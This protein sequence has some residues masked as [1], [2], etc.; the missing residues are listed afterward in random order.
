MEN[1][2]VS[3]EIDFILVNKLDTTK[4][5][6]TVLLSDSKLVIS[7]TNEKELCALYWLTVKRL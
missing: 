2:L 6:I 5:A 4:L 1:C 7:F 3:G